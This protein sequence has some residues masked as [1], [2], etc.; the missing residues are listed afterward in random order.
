MAY[1][2]R[3]LN[4]RTLS[5]FELLA[6]KQGECWCMFYQ[7]P[8][9]VGRGLSSV[10]R[11]ALNRRDKAKLVRGGRSHAI[12]V[13]EGKTPVGWCQYGPR[14]EL[15]RIDAG[16]GYRKVGP[17]AGEERIWRITCFFV[18]RAHRGKGVA[19][20]GLRAALESIK[21]RGGGIVE[22]FPVVSK[23]M[24]AVPE[25]RWFGTKRMFEREGFGAVAPLGMSGLLMR[26][27][28]RPVAA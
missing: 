9:P 1:I 8:R 7:R 24:A 3:E 16:R 26:K 22:A 11:K 2:T 27:T 4:A 10:Q 6:A 23:R 25:W 17:P 21:K 5:D 15:P 18:D 13:Y 12:L 20:I 14:E 28:I 19:T